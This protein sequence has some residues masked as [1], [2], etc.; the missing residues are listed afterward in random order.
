MMCDCWLNRNEITIKK[1]HEKYVDADRRL[2]ALLQLQ[3]QF[4][5]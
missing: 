1:M 4:Q 3:M 2:V 5:S